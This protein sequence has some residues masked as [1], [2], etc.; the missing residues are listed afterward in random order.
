M[1]SYFTN[2]GKDG[3]HLACSYDGYVWEALNNNESF[4]KPK[5]S[6]DSLMRDPCIVQGPDG[7]DSKL[8]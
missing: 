7:L 5:I 6:K 2:G 4:L 3:L 1:F 8:E